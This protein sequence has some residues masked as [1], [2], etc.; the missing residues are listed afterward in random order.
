M[1]VIKNMVDEKY[2]DPTKQSQIDAQLEASILK[3]N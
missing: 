2:G 1:L 3:H